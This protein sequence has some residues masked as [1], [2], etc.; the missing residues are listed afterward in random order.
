MRMFLSLVYLVTKVKLCWKK[1]FI[2]KLPSGWTKFLH[3]KT[4]EILSFPKYN[5]YVDNNYICVKLKDCSY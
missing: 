3:L 1:C 2:T 4:W 5:R